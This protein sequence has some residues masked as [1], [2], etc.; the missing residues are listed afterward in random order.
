MKYAYL[1]TIRWLSWS[2][3][4]RT[5]SEIN[6]FSIV[7]ST[8]TVSWT[9]FTLR[10]HQL[11]GNFLQVIRRQFSRWLRQ[12]LV[13]GELR[14]TPVRVHQSSFC[15]GGRGWLSAALNT[16]FEHM[17]LTSR[18]KAFAQNFKFLFPIFRERIICTSQLFLFTAITMAFN[19]KGKMS[20]QS[21][22][23][24]LYN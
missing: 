1:H 19:I 13:E 15:A 10:F 4:K 21:E 14:G 9:T 18:P 12:K 7:F 5:K 22:K 23:S 3:A 2:I 8:K 11:C 17:V 24:K 16:F 6:D 20:W